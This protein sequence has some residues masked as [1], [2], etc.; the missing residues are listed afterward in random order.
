MRNHLSFIPPHY[1]SCK[2]QCTSAIRESRTETARTNFAFRWHAPSLPPSLFFSLSDGRSF[3][4]FLPPFISAA[5]LCSHHQSISALSAIQPFG[6]ISCAVG[7]S[8]PPPH[9]S[10]RS[11]SGKERAKSAPPLPAQVSD[12]HQ[13]GVRELVATRHSKALG[14]IR[15]APR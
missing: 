11:S 2:F 6:V 14:H 4:H 9:L 13:S 12:Q 8:P 5:T 3:R 7:K 15:S 10:P 1:I